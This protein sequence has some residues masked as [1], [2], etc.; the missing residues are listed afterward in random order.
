MLL[1]GVRVDTAGRW[2]RRVTASLG[3]LV[4]WPLGALVLGLPVVADLLV[5]VL[6]GA[7]RDAVRPLAFPVLLDGRVVGLGERSLGL[8][9]RPLDRAGQLALLGGSLL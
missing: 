1:G 8:R 3:L 9:V 7:V 2:A 6:E 4:R 5:G